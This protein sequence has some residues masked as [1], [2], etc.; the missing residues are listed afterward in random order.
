MS[1]AA[2]SS[3]RS[4]NIESAMPQTSGGS[5]DPGN[6]DEGTLSSLE[7]EGQI[8]AKEI[9]RWRGDP[10]AATPAPSDGEIVMLKSHID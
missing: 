1:E 3:A 10:D 9:S 8:A 7:Q 5:W 4:S 6:L 2:E